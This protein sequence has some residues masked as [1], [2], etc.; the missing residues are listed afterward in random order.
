M[1]MYV[2]QEIGRT[3]NAI[4]KAEWSKNGKYVRLFDGNGSWWHPVASLVPILKT[5]PDLVETDSE[6]DDADAYAAWCTA[7]AKA[8]IFGGVNVSDTMPTPADFDA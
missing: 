3:T 6:E 2:L 8:G 7:T 5:L 1:S 4:S